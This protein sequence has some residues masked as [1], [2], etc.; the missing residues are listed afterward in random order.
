MYFLILVSTWSRAKLRD[1]KLRDQDQDQDHIKRDQDQDHIKLV[2]RRLETKTS[3]ETYNTAGLPGEPRPMAIFELLDYIVN[4]P[5][6]RLPP[7]VFSSEFIDLV[8][9]CLKKSPS[10]RA[11]LTTLQNHEWIKNA[12]HEDVD[13]AGWVCKTMDITPSTPTKPSAE[14]SC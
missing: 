3:L 7:G 1:Q 6:P 9:R 13:I 4:E 14:G 5:P 8:D 11:D 10:E 2:S 12:V